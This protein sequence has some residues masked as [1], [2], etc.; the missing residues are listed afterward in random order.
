MTEFLAKRAMAEVAQNADMLITTG[1]N[2][3]VALA[4]RQQLHEALRS[5]LAASNDQLVQCI[6]MTALFASNGQR[7]NAAMAELPEVQAAAQMASDAGL[8]QFPVDSSFK[9]VVAAHSTSDIDIALWRLLPYAF[10]ATY[11][12]GA[13]RS[14]VY[15]A[16]LGAFKT[17][18]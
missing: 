8:A 15:A 12:T 3:G 17:N 13:W 10:A 2:V 16:R 18:L 9:A 6:K 4:V 5:T 11:G 7:H 14:A 1:V